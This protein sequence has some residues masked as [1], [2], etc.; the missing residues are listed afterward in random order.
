MTRIHRQWHRRL[1]V[2]LALLVPL[3][4]AIGLLARRPVPV[5][6]GDTPSWAVGGTPKIP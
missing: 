1:A 5:M 6:S 2:V 3:L 4:F